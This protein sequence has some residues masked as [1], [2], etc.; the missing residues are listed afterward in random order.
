MID[1]CIVKTG[2]WE[3]VYIVLEYCDG[4]DLEEYLKENATKLSIND[5][6]DMFRQIID[7][8]R[9]LRKQKIIHRD[10]KAENILIHNN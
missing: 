3:R 10:V 6:I 7:G 8:F 5:I 2:G 9:Y 4:G 1:S